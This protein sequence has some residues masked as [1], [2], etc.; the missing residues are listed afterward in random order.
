MMLWGVQAETI[1]SLLSSC[2]AK[3]VIISDRP[4]LCMIFKGSAHYF[5]TVPTDIFAIYCIRINE[6][7]SCPLTYWLNSNLFIE[8]I[9]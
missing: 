4:C 5:C 7:Q 6:N 2:L 8:Q 3:K 9:S 1:F